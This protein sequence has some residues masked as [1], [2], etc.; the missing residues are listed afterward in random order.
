VEAARAGEQGRGFAVVASEVRTLAHRSAAAAKEIKTLIA[1]SVTT[2]D[3]GSVAVQ[4][5]GD[6]MGAIVASVQ[7][8]NDIIQRVQAA[9]AEQASGINEVNMAVAQMDDVTQQNA[10][11]VEQ[12]AAAAASLQD[13]AVTLSSAVAVF[14]LDQVMAPF[15]ATAPEKPSEAD[16]FQHPEEH[17]SSQAERRAL[18]SPLRGK[19]RA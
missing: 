3:G 18:Q 9:S 19:R 1:T 8:V 12:A 2:I 10:A 7:Q 4:Q 15:V 11:L 16:S 13:Q 14:T 5:A 6:S 17:R